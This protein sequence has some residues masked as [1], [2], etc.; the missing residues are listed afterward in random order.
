MKETNKKTLT[1]G[2]S[3]CPNDTFIFDALVN[4]KIEIGSYHFEPILEDVETLNRWALQ[5]KLDISKISYGV[6]PSVQSNY[7]LLN[8]GSALGKGVGPMLISKREIENDSAVIKELTVGIPGEHTTAHLLFSLAFPD[9]INKKFMIFSSIEEALLTEEIDCGVIIHESRFTY[10]QKG[11]KKIVDLGDYWEQKMRVPIPLGGIIMKNK[12]D[13]N[14]IGRIDGLIKNS[15]EYA[16]SNYPNL[17]QYVKEHSQEMEESVMRKHIDLYVNDFS[18]DLGEVGRNAI[19]E[20]TRVRRTAM[21]A[22]K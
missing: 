19:E 5:G 20:L 18:L 7:T 17:P 15:L 21:M 13:K 3:P 2:F 4:R 9:A 11:L 8:S 14:T 16:F 10:A 22:A 12:F 1:I 6:W